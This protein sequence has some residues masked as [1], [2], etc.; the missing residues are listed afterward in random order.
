MRKL[1]L[2][3]VMAIGMLYS[4]Q[5]QNYTCSEVY[6]YVV[7]NYDNHSGGMTY[8]T[9]SAL[10]EVDWYEVDGTNFAVVEFT[11]SSSKYIFCGISDYDKLMFEIEAIGS[12]GKS[13]W[14]YIQPY[15]CN[16]K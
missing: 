4:A 14:K 8:I 12:G 9:S 3:A 2:T 5:A 7:N 11:S 6:N 1:L 16:C 10:Y 13:Y 15:K